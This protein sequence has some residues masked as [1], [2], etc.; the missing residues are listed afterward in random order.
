MHNEIGLFTGSFDPVTIGHVDVI[1]RASRLFETLYVGIFYNQDK[2]GFLSLSQREL[3]LKK[4]LAHLPNVS[5]FTSKTRLVSDVAQELGVT[6]LVRGLR[7]VEDVTYEAS[8]DF[9]NHELAPDIETIYLLAKPQYHYISSSRV[10]E[11]ASFG[12]DFSKY[13]PQGVVEE[14]EKVL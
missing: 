10:R 6:T 7:G 8:L 11:L 9:F 14:V 2:R 5:V 1:E 12:T 3:C 4:A 13:V